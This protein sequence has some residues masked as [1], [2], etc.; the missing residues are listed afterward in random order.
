PGFWYDQ[1]EDEWVVLLSGSA[2]LA[3]EDGRERELGPGD[4]VRIPAHE[5]HRVVRTAPDRE[6]VWLAVFLK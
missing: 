6:T 5:K 4:H 2:T 3:W 1:D